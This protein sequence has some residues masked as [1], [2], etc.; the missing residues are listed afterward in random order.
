MLGLS[1][2]MDQLAMAKSVRWYCHVLR[3]EDGHFVSRSLCVCVYI[4]VCFF[5]GMSYWRRR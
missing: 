3:R 4:A 2:A 1:E 5:V